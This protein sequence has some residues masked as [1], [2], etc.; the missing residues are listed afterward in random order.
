[1]GFTSCLRYCSDVTHRR[2][3]KFCRCLAVSWADT[4]YIHFRGLLPPNRILRGAKFTLRSKSCIPY[5]QRY[6]TTLQQQ[7]SA[8]LCGVVQ[9]I[10]LWNFCRG[11]HQYLVGQPSC[12]ALPD[13][14]VFFWLATDYASMTSYSI[15]KGASPV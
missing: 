5:R 6:C 9:G 15:I 13:I 11:R 12:W 4:L 8:K 14:P 7:A 3:T 1:M 2:P 10:E